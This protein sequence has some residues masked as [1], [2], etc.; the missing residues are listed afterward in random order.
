VDKRN[1]VP[2]GSYKPLGDRQPPG[3]EGLKAQV[4]FGAAIALVVFLVP[5]SFPGWPRWLVFV[6]KGAI[7]LGLIAVIHRNFLKDRSL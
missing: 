4:L 3:P 1:K 7:L 6:A 5:N 2:F